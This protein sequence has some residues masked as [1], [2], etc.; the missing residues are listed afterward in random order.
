MKYPIAALLLFIGIVL[1]WI[2]FS[3]HTSLSERERHWNERQNKFDETGWELAQGF[4]TESSWKSGPKHREDYSVCYLCYGFGGG[5]CLLAL[6][7]L[8][9]PDQATQ[10]TSDYNNYTT[11]MPRPQELFRHGFSPAGL[12][13]LAKPLLDESNYNPLVPTNASKRIAEDN[14]RKVE[15]ENQA[16]ERNCTRNNRAR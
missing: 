6:F 10:V 16:A 15:Q 12:D 11:D 1:L 3:Q 8:A 7:A 9:I 14:A 5:A 13:M 2:G 4:G